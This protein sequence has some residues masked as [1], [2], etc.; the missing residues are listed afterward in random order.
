MARPTKDG[1][2]YFPLNT[3]NDDKFDLIEARHGLIGYAIIVK[4]YQKIY[5]EFGYF[6]PWGERQKL[7]FSRAI[8]MPIEEINTVVESAVEFGLFDQGQYDSGILTSKG[9]QRRY[10]EASK[11]RK[12]VKL[13]SDILLII[14][15]L[16]DKQSPCNGVFT[17]INPQV[18]VLNDGN[19]PQS[20]EESKEESSGG[21]P[22]LIPE[23]TQQ[24]EYQETT[25]T[26]SIKTHVKSSTGY[27][28]DDKVAL[29]FQES[30]IP[31]DWVNT[32]FNFFM[33]VKNTVA[34]K[35][36]DKSESEKRTL[37]ISAVSD[38][39][40]LREEYPAWLKKQE[41]SSRKKAVDAARDEKPKSCIAC[42]STKLVGLTP[43]TISCKA[44]GGFYEFDSKQNR[45]VFYPAPKDIQD[46]DSIVD[47]LRKKSGITRKLPDTF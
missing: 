37:F 23:I 17:G 41:T 39:Q 38:W 15:E 47:S 5:N 32:Q 3:K 33:F 43:D 24:N 11:K 2:D 22:E 46:T 16:T 34:S 10:F 14:P 28:I 45:Y 35:Y 9:I 21:K 1:L 19:N 26:N 6:Y 25:T 27:V 8:L 31:D 7:L 30:Q 40:N 42:G 29:R 44:C 36:P 12:V 4:L 18:S 20:K 13:Y